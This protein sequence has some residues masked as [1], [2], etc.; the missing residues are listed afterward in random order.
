MNTYLVYLEW[1]EK[2]FRADAEALR[3]LRANVPKGSRTV[4]VRSDAAFL[5]ALPKATHVLTW[6]FRQEWF[7]LA[8]RMKVLAT[9]AAGREF[10]ATDAPKGV[11]V[12]FGGFHSAII[13]EAVLAFVLAWTHGFFQVRSVPLW[14]RAI[15]A[16]FVDRDLAGSRAVILGYGRIGRGIGR[17]LEA[18]GVS[19][20]GYSR[21][22]K[23]AP[24]ALDREL[25]RAD[26]LI[27]A[28]PSDTG[29]DNLVDARMLAKVPGRCVFVNVGRGNC[30]DERALLE[31]LKAKRIAGAYLD[32]YRHEPTVLAKKVRRPKRGET[33][34]ALLPEAKCPWNLI[35]MPHASAYS[36]SYLRMF[37]E[38]L[39]GEG[40]I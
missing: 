32:V 38:E 9:P 12:H 29:T 30:V 39:K 24:A 6:H 27:A 14:P 10:V 15:L 37:F 40:L 21:H 19:V 34:L 3:L 1:P 11:T 22:L 36:P 16:D 5:R 7:A 4:R 2:C 20:F 31:A 13:S 18:F 33:D 23:V 35:R 17:R 28:L 25:R 8:P 26:W